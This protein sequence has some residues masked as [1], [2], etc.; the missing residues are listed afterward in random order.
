MLS[1][2]ARRGPVTGSLK[3]PVKTVRPCHGTSFGRP[4]LT[5]ISFAMVASLPR[6]RPAR[7]GSVERDAL[8]AAGGEVTAE[9][10]VDHEPLAAPRAPVHD[11]PVLEGGEGARGL[12]GLEVRV[13]PGAG[14]DPDRHP[15]RVT[16]ERADELELLFVAQPLLAHRA[17]ERLHDERVV[18]LAAQLL[19]GAG[20]RL[21]HQQH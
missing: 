7:N 14:R 19:H 9:Q 16:A 15:L 10:R 5:E 17:L 11:P 12:L 1:L 8:G 18:D 6:S 21:L 2:P 4:T 3:T 20:V 13:E